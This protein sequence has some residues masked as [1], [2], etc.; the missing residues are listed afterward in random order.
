M[1]VLTKK[2]R[3]EYL[4]VH[5]ESVGA[6]FAVTY[7]NSTLLYWFAKFGKRSGYDA[8]FLESPCSLR[9][10]KIV[11]IE[12]KFYYTSIGC[13]IKANDYAYEIDNPQVG[14]FLPEEIDIL[15]VGSK[16]EE[17]VDWLLTNTY[18]TYIWEN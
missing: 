9:R 15:Y 10:F 13:T 5:I 8:W 14:P 6:Y 11:D 2:D 17:A 16:E 3:E 18:A 12:D 7:E 1:K 4:E